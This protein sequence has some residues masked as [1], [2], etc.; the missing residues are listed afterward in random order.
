MF[1]QMDRCL[2]SV[3]NIPYHINCKFLKYILTLILEI[4]HTVC[5]HFIAK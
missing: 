3:I 4:Y 1:E 5:F 2:L